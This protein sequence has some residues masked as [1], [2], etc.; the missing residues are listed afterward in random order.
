MNY[1]TNVESKSCCCKKF[2][3]F[4]YGMNRTYDLLLCEIQRDPFWE[5]HL[6]GDLFFTL[7][8]YNI[9]FKILL[10]VKFDLLKTFYCLRIFWITLVY[11]H[12]YTCMWYYFSL[13]PSFVLCYSKNKPSIKMSIEHIDMLSICS[14]DMFI[15][16]VTG[17]QCLWIH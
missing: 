17:I 12:V 14:M 15:D 9:W 6:H 13:D 3:F 7:G 4:F 11:L 10:C 8:C 1:Y 16:C 2:T 5:L